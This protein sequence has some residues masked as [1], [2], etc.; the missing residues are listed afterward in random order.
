MKHVG[1]TIVLMATVLA[2][3]AS[4]LQAERWGRHCYRYPGCYYGWDWGYDLGLLYLLNNDW[5]TQRRLAQER[6]LVGQQIAAQQTAA[7]Q[8]SIH[9]AAAADG[10]RRADQ[11]FLQQQAGRD[12][13]G[14]VQ[15]QQIAARQQAAML[16]A[17]AAPKPEP[18]A[19]AKVATDVVKW[20]PLL[21]GTQFAE[22]RTQIEAPYRRK[23][24]SPI[25][26]TAADYQKMLQG[27][28]QMQSTVKTMAPGITAQQFFDA[29]A[30]LDHLTADIR[31][32][33]DKLTVKK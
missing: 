10:Q 31:G 4:P 28:E 9:D 16:T 14:Q 23:A 11:M 18:S 33:L 7:L 25:A 15:Q 17:M 3:L 6:N 8:R 27:V 32:R 5:N 22:Q 24:K 26:P 12:W 20:P 19:A 1:L 21:Q 13:W 2:I 30:F 29:R